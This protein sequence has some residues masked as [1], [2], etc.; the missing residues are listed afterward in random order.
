MMPVRTPW[1]TNFAVGHAAIDEQHR[2]LLD[3][4]NALAELCAVDGG[5][6]G[7]D[8][9]FIAAYDRLMTLAREHFAAEEARLVAGNSPELENYRFEIEEYGYLAAEIATA[10]NF[11]RIELQRFVALWWIGHIMDAV[12]QPASRLQ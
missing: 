4:C 3:Q 5:N 1:D 11:D 7:A 8:P 12:K 10:E 9:Q 6:S 2:Q